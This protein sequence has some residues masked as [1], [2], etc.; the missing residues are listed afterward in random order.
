MYGLMKVIMPSFSILMFVSCSGY[1][2]H[3]QDNISPKSVSLAME[4]G[5][6]L[7]SETANDITPFMFRNSN[8]PYIFFASTRSGTL[9]IYYAQMDPAEKFFNLTELGTGINI[10]GTLAFSPVV[11][12]NGASTYVSFISVTG[13]SSAGFTNLVITYSVD[14]NFNPDGK[15]AATNL[16]PQGAPVLDVQDISYFVGADNIPYLMLIEK[17]NLN[18]ISLYAFSSGSWTPTNTIAVPIPNN[19]AAGYQVPFGT[20]TNLYLLN[21]NTAGSK[22]QLGGEISL[23]GPATNTSTFSIPAYAS[24]YNDA[25][26]FIDIADNYKVYF[27]SD[28]YGKGYYNLYRYNITTYNA[29]VPSAQKSA[30]FAVYVAPSGSGGN[31]ANSGLSSSSPLL[32]I[33]KAISNA[34]AWGIQFVLIEEGT[35]TPGAGLEASSSGVLMNGVAP[36][37]AS[38]ILVYGGLNSTFT[39]S[40]GISVLDAQNTGITGIYIQN[41]SNIYFANISV[42]NASE[43]VYMSGDYDILFAN[44]VFSNN[45]SSGIN[46][47]GIYINSTLAADFE[48]DLIV[49]NTGDYGGGI[50]VDGDGSGSIAVF[51]NCII[52]NNS[53]VNGGGIDF[54]DPGVSTSATLSGTTLTNNTPND[55]STNVL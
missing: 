4:G 44:S 31:D 6:Y 17:T 47:G 13:S 14:N 19:S 36:A 24:G 1:F 49:N 55:I 33:Q 2:S 45:G 8:G 42:I 10:P 53:A 29:Q 23:T 28:R 37:A 18:Q 50:C 7:S 3:N 16:N 9:A 15:S 34:Y 12:Q 20:F 43:G 25:Y 40:N 54:V 41:S 52:T 51:A 39:T 26:P 30:P 32:T 35:Y 48:N 27:S 46:G 38:Q 21:A 11:F 5:G 22:S